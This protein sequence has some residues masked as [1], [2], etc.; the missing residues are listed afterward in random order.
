MVIQ[1]IILALAL[2]IDAFGIGISYGFKKIKFDFLSIL[3]ISMISLVF[4]SLSIGFG[5]IIEDIF[6]EKFLGFISILILVLLG[7]FIIKKGLEKEENQQDNINN[8]PK[9]ISFFI[10]GLG[11]TIKIIKNPSSCD[12]NNSFKIEAK[13]ALFLGIALSIDAIGTG[14]AVSSF[15]GYAI[16][17]P[18]FIVIFQLSFLFLGSLLGSLTK[19]SKLDE[20]KISMISGLTLIF[21]AILRLI[22]YSI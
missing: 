1:L 17:F 20:S 4:S 21:I 11:L 7:I 8:M 13:E 18:I 6:S 12:L 10:K 2:S 3:V 16:L 22:S 19:F 14:I 5:N 9:D 15:D